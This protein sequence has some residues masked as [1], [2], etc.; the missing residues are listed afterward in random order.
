MR[1]KTISRKFKLDNDAIEFCAGLAFNRDH[2]TIV[3][4][5]GCTDRVA[6]FLEL[7]ES[8]VGSVL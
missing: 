5:Y 6:R 7:D 2:E 8:V 1:P 3:L 4:S